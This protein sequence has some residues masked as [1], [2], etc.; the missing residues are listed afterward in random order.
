MARR[1]AADQRGPV[2]DGVFDFRLA[3]R[4][5]RAAAT[6]GSGVDAERL[7]G[8]ALLGQGRPDDAELVLAS[9]TP[10]A[11]PTTN[12]FRSPSAEP[13]TCTGHWT[14]RRGQGGTAPCRAGAHRPWQPR[15]TGSRPGWPS[16]VRR[17]SHPGAP[18]AGTRPHGPGRGRSFHPAGTGGSHPGAFMPAAASRRSWGRPSSIRARKTG[19][20]KK[21][22]PESPAGRL[23]PLQRL[24]GSRTD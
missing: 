14:S 5:A 1:W 2:G 16:A 4:L 19:S 23:E 22:S 10:S 11:E 3:E 12:A 17:R 21:S 9:L 13:S 18:R 6:T 24:S 15:R 20:V 7:V 8:L